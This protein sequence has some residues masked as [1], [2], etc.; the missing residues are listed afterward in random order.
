MIAQWN[1]G[2]LKGFFTSRHLSDTT[3]TAIELIP[4]NVK[5]ARVGNEDID[6][7]ALMVTVTR[8]VEENMQSSVAELEYK[9]SFRQVVLRVFAAGE[10]TAS[11]YSVTYEGRTYWDENHEIP[12]EAAVAAMQLQGLDHYASLLNE[13]KGVSE[14]TGLGSNIVDARASFNRDDLLNQPASVSSGSNIDSIMIWAIVIAVV[15][16]ILL[17]AAIFLA[18]RSG[19][20]EKEYDEGLA[21]DGDFDVNRDPRNSTA[22][23]ETFHTAGPYPESVISEDISS[24]LS[25]YYKQ[26]MTGGY[27]TNKDHTGGLNDAASVSSMESYGYSLDGYASSIAN[28]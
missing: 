27:R 1:T 4:F 22:P 17:G 8:W 2:P 28:N 25:A 19:K 23:A 11:S 5:L 18:W 9:Y 12:T 6:S 14:S 10:N 21:T 16:S 13:L 3:S 7:V 15:A 26:G 24:S 20:G